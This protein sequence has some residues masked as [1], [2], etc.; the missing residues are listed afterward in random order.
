MNISTHEKTN[1]RRDKERKGQ[2]HTQTTRHIH[3]DKQARMHYA[4]ICH[5]QWIFASSFVEPTRT[6]FLSRIPCA[7]K[8]AAT[9]RQ[10]PESLRVLVRVT[11]M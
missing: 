1:T 8:T 6:E 11:Q 10:F 9:Q 7:R 3:R 5:R 4:H 2:T